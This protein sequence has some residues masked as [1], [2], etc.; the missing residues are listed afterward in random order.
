LTHLVE[1]RAPRRYLVFIHFHRGRERFHRQGHGNLVD[2][3]DFMPDDDEDFT[4]NDPQNVLESAPGETEIPTGDSGVLVIQPADPNLLR[5]TQNGDSIVIGFNRVDIPDEV[6][7]AGYREQLLQL[8]DR[9][10]D[11]KALTF[12]VTGIKLLPSGMLGLL[13]SLKRR[14]ANI[15][16]LNPA[17]DVLEALRVTRLTTL[18]KIRNT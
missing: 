5:I 10:P 17:R 9:N 14:I 13:A 18:F 7:I 12:D 15:E 16:V 8:L 1:Q 11:C 3:G 2:T 6:C 4:I